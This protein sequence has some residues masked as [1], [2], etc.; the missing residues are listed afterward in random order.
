M[1]I[2]Q[3]NIN[4][5]GYYYVN[6]TF[7]GA[8][9]RKTCLVHRMVA[10]SFLPKLEDKEIINHKDGDKLNNHVSNLEWCTTLENN[11]HAI[12]H[13]LI[14]FA[15]GEDVYAS[16]L[17]EQQVVYILQHY[18]PRSRTMGA[19]SL[20]RRFNVDKSTISAI[21]NKKS[22]FHIDRNQFDNPYIKK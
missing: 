5:N 7:G 19:R 15:K 9:N 6:L 16:V 11:Q 14:D 8:H 18:I 13:N 22:W 21:V 1:K 10:E 20:G 2:R 4:H 17:T 3:L 12:N